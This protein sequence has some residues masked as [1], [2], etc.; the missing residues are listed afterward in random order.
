MFFLDNFIY[1]FWDSVLS[2]LMHQPC[3]YKLCIHKL[4]ALVSLVSN[5]CHIV[6][7]FCCVEGKLTRRGSSDTAGDVDS[8]GTKHFHSHHNLPEH[9]NS[10]S[11]NTIK[12]GGKQISSTIIVLILNYCS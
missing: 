11:D 1:I 3:P 5:Y 8:L 10:H 9:S 6:A 7:V 4:L 12:E 2:G